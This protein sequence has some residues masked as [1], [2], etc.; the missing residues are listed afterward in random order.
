[1]AVGLAVWARGGPSGR[2]Q[3]AP[4]LARASLR[5]SPG[6]R[7]AAGLLCKAG[8]DQCVHP[9]GDWNLS[10]RPRVQGAVGNKGLLPAGDPG[11][12]PPSSSGPYVGRAARKEK[13]PR[14]RVTQ[15]GV[16]SSPEGCGAGCGWKKPLGA[17]GEGHLAFPHW[18]PGGPPP[19]VLGDAPLSA[20]GRGVLGRERHLAGPSV[21][22]RWGTRGGKEGKS[23]NSGGCL[24]F[25][26]ALTNKHRVS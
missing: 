20:V 16:A 14:S 15:P 9:F 10:E 23:F 18:G 8:E 25:S 17:A 6:Q 12:P 5:G 24:S 11:F 26:F 4:G 2:L 3:E 13:E 7:P 19:L 21:G 22:D 1:M